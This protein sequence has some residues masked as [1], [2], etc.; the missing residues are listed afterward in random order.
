LDDDYLTWI[1]SI[2]DLND[3]NHNGIPDL[4]DD[5]AVAPPRRPDFG[6]QRVGT[7]LEFTIHGDVGHRHLLQEASVVNGTTWDTIQTLNLATDPQTVS[8]PIPTTNRFWRVVAQ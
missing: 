6:V 2:D 7:L 1:L 5:A 3:A 4:S 8:V